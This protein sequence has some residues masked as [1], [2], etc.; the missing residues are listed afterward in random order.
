VVFSSGSYV[1][2][3][4]GGLS[5]TGNANISGTGVM[6]YFTG[7]ATINVTGTPTLNLNAPAT[8][9]YAGMLMWQDAAD[10]ANPSLSANNGSQL[11]GILYFPS[12][13]LTFA[14]NPNL[15]VGAVVAGSVSVAGGA[16]VTINGG[17]INGGPGVPGGLPTPFTAPSAVLVE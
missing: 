6:F 9:Q 15:N 1:I 14:A 2:N 13:Q 7:P 12:D 3:G 17:A 8:G 10:T 4:A 5:V 16:N 11:N